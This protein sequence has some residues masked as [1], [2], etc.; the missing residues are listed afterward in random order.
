MSSIWTTRHWVMH[1]TLKQGPPAD[2]GDAVCFQSFAY[3][4]TLA[5]MN[6]AECATDA[7]VCERQGGKRMIGK[8]H[9]AIRPK[10]LPR[11]LLPGHEL[12]RDSSNAHQLQH[13]NCDSDRRWRR[14]A[15]KLIAC[16]RDHVKNHAASLTLVGVC[17]S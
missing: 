6:Q 11:F 4:P 13:S 8:H 10:S 16:L 17:P 7:E 14:H 2:T 5:S 3:A 15:D 12:R 9:P 1:R